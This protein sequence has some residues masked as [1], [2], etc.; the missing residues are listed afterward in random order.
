MYGVWYP[1]RH[2]RAVCG[3][4][5]EKLK[6]LITK[7]RLVS[8]ETVFEY[9]SV[10]GKRVGYMVQKGSPDWWIRRVYLPPGEVG[11]MPTTLSLGEY[12]Y[13]RD[14]IDVVFKLI[15]AKLKVKRARP[16]KTKSKSDILSYLA[17]CWDLV[18]AVDFLGRYA[19]VDEEKL[20]KALDRKGL[21]GFSAIHYIFEKYAR[22][23]LKPWRGGDR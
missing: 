23:A 2:Q 10:N 7:H 6:A 9:T 5:H 16:T 22:D 18:D 4:T 20:W 14:A 12:R 21:T 15:A 11:W 1:M 17:S 19:G 8:G 13:Q 3:M